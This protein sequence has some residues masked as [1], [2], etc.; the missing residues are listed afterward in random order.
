M[1]CGWLIDI[2]VESRIF[3]RSPGAGDFVPFAASFGEAVRFW[4]ACCE[5]FT[6]ANESDRTRVSLDFRVVPR[7][8]HRECTSFYVGGEPKGGECRALPRLFAAVPLRRLLTPSSL[9][10][11]IP[12]PDA[13]PLPLPPSP[14]RL[15]RRHGSRWLTA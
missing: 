10:A 2:C 12:P 1:T 8:V 7:S 11:C 14:H 9:R 6:V 3:D 13:V 5:H 4:G 15:L